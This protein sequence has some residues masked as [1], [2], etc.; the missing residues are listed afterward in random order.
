MRYLKPFLMAMICTVLSAC[1]VDEPPPEVEDTA[2]GSQLAPLNKA[3]N[4]QL[5][6]E[7]SLDQKRDELD[8]HIDGLGQEESRQRRI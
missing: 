4:F 6:Y 1:T 8:R 2:I 3:Q 5:E 7:K